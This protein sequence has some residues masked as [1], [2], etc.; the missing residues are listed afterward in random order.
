MEWV[1]GLVLLA[2]AGVSY[3]VQ[4]GHKNRAQREA[5]NERAARRAELSRKY[6]D[7]P[8]LP[9]LLSGTIRIGMTLE[10]VID[11]WGQPAG[12]EE[13]V[14]KTKTT[15]TLKYGQINS[16]SFRQQVKLENGF[17]VGWTNR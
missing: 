11:S 2:L 16:R 17:V 4:Q 10:Q 8:H 3:M 6:T 12:I 9:D 14:L 5:D 15:Q 1:V 7:S 13:R